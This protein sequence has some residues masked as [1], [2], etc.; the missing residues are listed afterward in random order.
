[1][2]QLCGDLAQ[3]LI[4][5]I[6]KGSKIPQFIYDNKISETILTMLALTL[7]YKKIK[8][9]KFQVTVTWAKPEQGSLF[10]QLKETNSLNLNKKILLNSE[11]L[12][13]TLLAAILQVFKIRRFTS[14][15]KIS[16]TILTILAITPPSIKKISIH[17]DLSFIGTWH[18]QKMALSS[19]NLQEQTHL[20]DPLNSGRD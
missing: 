9:S 20:F 3:T 15:N 6:L 13:H 7:S 4:V 17:I 12:P 5:A 2:Y 14:N 10:L 1:M 19:W 16:E 11:D 8:L 18:T